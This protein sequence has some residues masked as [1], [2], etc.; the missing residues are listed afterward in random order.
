MNGC[1]RVGSRKAGF[2]P[3]STRSALLSISTRTFAFPQV[4]AWREQLSGKKRYGRD[5]DLE[6]N[7]ARLDDPDLSA[8]DRRFPRLHCHGGIALAQATTPIPA[9]S[10][11]PAAPA[12]NAAA[13]SP[14]TPPA[15]LLTEA[16]LAQL[17]A[18]I[19]MYPDPLLAQILMASTYPLEVVEASRWV[20]APANQALAE[21]KRRRVILA[22]KCAGNVGVQPWDQGT[23]RK[24]ILDA[25]DASLHRLG[26]DYV[27]VYQLHRYDPQTPL[28]E[29]L[30]ALD[31]VVRQGKARYVGASNWPTRSPVRSAAAKPGTSCGSSRRSRGT[32]CCSGALSATSCRSAPRWVNRQC[33]TS[34][35]I[36]RRSIIKV[37]PAADKRSQSSNAM[38]GSGP[39]NATRLSGK[40]WLWSAK[41][42]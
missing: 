24:H 42:A 3:R 36:G 28:D 34:T 38:L 29:A 8:N 16:Q 10:P 20:S 12:P 1:R 39:N 37:T 25:I 41:R 2:L 23:S 13:V 40:E 17:V 9:P 33:G 26:T 5:V 7:D 18:P 22:T 27:D 15:Q 4:A 21:G 19:A 31:T 35:W 30:D 6:G 32:I 11:P 14:A